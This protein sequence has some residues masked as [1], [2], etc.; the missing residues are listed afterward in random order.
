L[1]A[2]G[3][4]KEATSSDGVMMVSEN[5]VEKNKELWV[6]IKESEGRRGDADLELLQ[7]GREL[8]DGHGYKLTALNLGAN[9]AHSAVELIGFGADTVLVVDDKCLKC[10]DAAIYAKQVAAV[11]TKYAPDI[12]LIGAD[13]FGKELA[14]RVA[15]R[16]GAGLTADCVDLSI[17]DEGMLLQAKPSFGGQIMVNMV[18]SS[19]RPQMATIR[20][21]VFAGASFDSSRQGEIVNEKSIVKPR[22]I[23]SYIASVTPA[24]LNEG[25][26]KR[27]EDAEI[28]I[29]GGN[30]FKRREDFMLLYELAE[31]LGAVVGATRPVVSKGWI[32]E[33]YQIGQSGKTISPE[34]YIAFGISGAVQHT[35]GVVQP[36]SFIA[37][38]SDENAEIFSAATIGIVDDCVSFVKSMICMLNENGNK[39]R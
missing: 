37:V 36:E 33:G 9:I 24:S 6:F 31:L 4:S 28:V 32:D 5:M 1:A 27:I 19:S 39:K 22:D 30:G 12:L 3:W 35:A 26:K 14:P 17:S 18:C 20:P 13:D 8:A 15:T 7:K 11:V 38:N 10:S 16:L 29:A 2:A 34:C 25:S 21:H 23:L